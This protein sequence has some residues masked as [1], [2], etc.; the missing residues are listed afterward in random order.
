LEDVGE[1]GFE[2]GEDGS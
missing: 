1:Y 2:R